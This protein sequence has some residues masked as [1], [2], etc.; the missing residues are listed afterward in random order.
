MHLSGPALGMLSDKDIQ[1]RLVAL[2]TLYIANS[3]FI[4]GALYSLQ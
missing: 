2:K 4:W 3:A 1:G